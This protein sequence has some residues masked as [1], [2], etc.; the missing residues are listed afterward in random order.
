VQAFVEAG[1]LPTQV[2]RAVHERLSQTGLVLPPGYHY[3]FGG[4]VEQRNEAIR[5]L[6]SSAD[7]LALVMAATLVLIFG[8]FRL[9]ALLAMVAVLSV[10]SALASLG[11]GGC[12]FGFMAILGTMGLVGLAINDSIVVLAAI[13]ADSAARRGDR[14]AICNV[15]VSSTRHVL[16]TTITTVMGLMP[17]LIFGGDFWGPLAIAVAGGVVGST[18]LALV[19]VPS[20]YILLMCR[21]RGLERSH[22]PLVHNL[23]NHVPC[24]VSKDA[25]LLSSGD[26]GAYF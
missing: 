3:E 23:L 19:F 24:P 7:T 9:A 22:G 1:V 21:A 26:R 13:R 20:F 25:H 18:L 5:N 2:L 8:S 11:L 16:A 6:L 10:G 12:P 14:E 17:L 4:E 15:V